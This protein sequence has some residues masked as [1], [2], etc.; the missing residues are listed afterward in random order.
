MAGEVPI[1]PTNASDNGQIAPDG[2][3]GFLVPLGDEI[4]MANRIMRFI[5]D[6][7]LKRR[8]GLNAREWIERHFSSQRLAEKTQDVYL[9]AL[10][11]R[12][13]N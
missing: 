13:R 3:V 6:A 4:A 8:M 11:H 1:D 5:E 12:S 7:E 10:S 2:E 9:E